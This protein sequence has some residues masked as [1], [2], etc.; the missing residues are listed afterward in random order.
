MCTPAPI[1][2]LKIVL[3]HTFLRIQYY[4]QRRGAYM[5]GAVQG[6][7]VRFQGDKNAFLATHD[8]EIHD[9]IYPNKN[10]GCSLYVNIWLNFCW[11]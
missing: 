7:R 10:K 3:L 8:F 1:F 4:S 2:F 11:G 9:A 6:Y 5:P